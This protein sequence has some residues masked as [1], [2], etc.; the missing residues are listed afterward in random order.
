MLLVVVLPLL[1]VPVL[2]LF[3]LPEVLVVPLLMVE[4]S[5]VDVPVGEVE[6]MVPDEFEL[7]PFVGV[8]SLV[9]VVVL[10]ELVF[11]VLCPLTR[12]V[13]SRLNASSVM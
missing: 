5:L 1:I 2:L 3:M 11:V 13:P 10:D 8:V 4:P 6:F 12:L 7:V 9:V